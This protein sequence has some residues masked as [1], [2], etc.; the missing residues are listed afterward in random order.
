MENTDNTQSKH[1]P[2]KANNTRHSKTKQPWF[3]HFL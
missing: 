1:N 2:E 3:S